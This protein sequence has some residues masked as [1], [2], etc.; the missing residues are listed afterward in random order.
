MSEDVTLC[1]R[2]KSNTA[3]ESHGCPYAEDI[4]GD[5]DTKCDCCDD[6]E[7]QCAMDI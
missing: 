2:C 3:K 4:G 1:R 6:C 5:Y 7:H